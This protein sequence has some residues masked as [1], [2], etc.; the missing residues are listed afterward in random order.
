MVVARVVSETHYD[1][2]LL[3]VAATFVPGVVNYWRGKPWWAL[4]LYDE[5]TMARSRGR[6]AGE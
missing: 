5:K 4:K 6:F 3:Y 2:L 1:W